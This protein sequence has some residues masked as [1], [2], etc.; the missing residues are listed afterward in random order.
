MGN[1]RVIDLSILPPL[2]DFISYR[3]PQTANVYFA[4]E[5]QIAS[6]AMR[7]FLGSMDGCFSQ[8]EEQSSVM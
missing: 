5:E 7:L 1:L 4:F 2:V 3:D 8:P 6:F